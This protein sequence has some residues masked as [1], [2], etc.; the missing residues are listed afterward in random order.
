MPNMTLMMMVTTL[1]WNMAVDKKD[2]VQYLTTTKG[3]SDDC[4]CSS[5]EQKIALNDLHS[6]SK[7]LFKKM[8]NI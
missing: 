7:I 1:N 2:H 3:Y 8:K 6:G 4:T 5:P